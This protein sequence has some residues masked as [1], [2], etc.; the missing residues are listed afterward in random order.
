MQPLLGITRGLIFVIVI[1]MTYRVHRLLT[2]M[3]PT[4]IKDW[5][6]QKWPLCLSQFICLC[7]FIS[8]CGAALF[9][10]SLLDSLPPPGIEWPLCPGSKYTPISTWRS[11]CL[12]SVVF[13]GNLPGSEGGSGSLCC[14]GVE[15]RGCNQLCVW[16]NS[17]KWSYW[18]SHEPVRLLYE[19]VKG[20]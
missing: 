4:P 17:N 16:N 9:A 20:I 7:W 8:L 10:S 18:C 11:V 19:D 2:T 3:F 14:R 5:N 13:G 1:F 6:G 15:G 12:S